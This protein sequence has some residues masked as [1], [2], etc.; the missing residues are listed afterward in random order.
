MVVQ[1]GPMR[2]AD[3]LRVSEIERQAF[4][5]LWPPTSFKREM[6][7]GL[8]KYLVAWEPGKPEGT[9]TVQGW[10]TGEEARPSHSPLSTLA[11]AT[12]AGATLAR[13]VKGRCSP[14]RTP[15][16]ATY[17]ILG[18]VGLWFMAD[19]AHITAIAVDETFRGNGF[20][21]LLLISSIELAKRRRAK[22]VSLEARVSNHIA[23]SLYLKYGF[24]KMGIRKGY[25]TDNREDAVI[26]ATDPI[27]ALSYEAKL[28][29]LKDAYRT[30]YSEIRMDLA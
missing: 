11:R 24:K 1:I 2:P 4:P 16:D 28:E 25:Y 27:D 10:W 19:E 12:L 13:A 18:F 6:E 5:T 23:Q 14:A 26:M 29:A 9:Q 15:Q 30:R 7:N 21:E 17:D 20:G 3:I 8:A 22:L